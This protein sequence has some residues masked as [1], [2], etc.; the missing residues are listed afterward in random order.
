[1]AGSAANPSL[2]VTVPIA[3]GTVEG[4]HFSFVARI[5]TPVH[6]DIRYNGAVADDVISGEITIAVA[7]SFP[8]VGSRE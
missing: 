6:V 4:N 7:G 2:G 3:G 1:M 5:T 8:C